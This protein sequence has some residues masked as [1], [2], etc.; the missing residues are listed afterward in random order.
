M[1]SLHAKSRLCGLATEAT[2]LSP[3]H[4]DG[5]VRQ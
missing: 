5:F 2:V 4:E 3:S 1:L